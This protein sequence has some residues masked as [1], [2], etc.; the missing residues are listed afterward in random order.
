MKAHVAPSSIK[1]GMTISI[2]VCSGYVLDLV[3]IV[4][5]SSGSLDE[6][7]NW[8]ALKVFLKEM[9]NRLDVGLTKTRI[10]MA[11]YDDG[12]NRIFY[13]ET[14]DDV[15]DILDEIDALELEGGDRSLYDGLRALTDSQ[16][17]SS[18]GDRDEVENV[19]V[20]I[21][22]GAANADETRTIDKAQDV[23]DDGVYIF[24]VGLSNDVDKAEIAAISSPPQKEG[25]QYYR[26]DFVDLDELADNITKQICSEGI[27][28]EESTSAPTM[29]VITTATPVGNITTPATPSGMSL[30]KLSSSGC[31]HCPHRR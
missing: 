5:S 11:T 2:P 29:T 16:F 9:V 17:R 27:L 12:S 21:A 20:V 28:G 30:L 26:S 25:Q 10:G 18:R 6:N 22:T 7:D 4:D 13:L 23:Q 19:A 3:F 31:Y 8:E 24:A 15:S 14:Y 1:T